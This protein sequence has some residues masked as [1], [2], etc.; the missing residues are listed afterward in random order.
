MNPKTYLYT[1]IAMA[2]TLIFVVLGGFMMIPKDIEVST[3]TPPPYVE[4]T[5]GKDS[6]SM[7]EKDV[8]FQGTVKEK[9]EVSVT[10]AT[11][12][13]EDENGEIV[14]YLKASDDKLKMVE[15][16]DV[17]V[18]GERLRLVGGGIPLVLVEEVKFR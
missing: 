8:L 2:V 14:A 15:R 10:G 4:A 6:N 1:F 18:V 16:M 17:E 3:S 12:Q 5:G 11:H 7:S 9:E 13:L